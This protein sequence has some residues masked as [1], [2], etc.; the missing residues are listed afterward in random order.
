MGDAE[1]E[2]DA[3]KGRSAFSGEEG[4][5]AVARSFHETVLLV[6]LRQAVR[7]ETDMEG[8]G[9]LLPDDQCTKTG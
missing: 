3:C 6:N 5:D 2:G 9:C 7:Q 1:A 4:G 8:G